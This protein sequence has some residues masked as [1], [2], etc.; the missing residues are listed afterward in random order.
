MHVKSLA[1]IATIALYIGTANFT[2]LASGSTDLVRIPGG[3]SGMTA[4]ATVEGTVPASA[5]V[6]VAITLPLRNQPEL[7]ALLDDLYNPLSPRY[8]HFLTPEQFTAEYSPTLSDYEVVANYARRSGLTIIGTHANR[9]ILDVTAP[10]SIVS[11][12]F[13]VHLRTWSS[14]TGEHFMAPD[15]APS[16]PAVVAAKVQSV[17]GLENAQKWHTHITQPDASVLNFQQPFQVGSGPN[18]ALSPNDIKSAYHL[19]TL[20]LTGTGQTLALFELDGF[21]QADVNAYRNY[22]GIG[23]P[24]DSVVLLDGFS[25][26]AGNGASEVTLDIQLMNALA[27]GAKVMVYEAPNSN[28]GVVDAYARIASDNIA[29]EVSSSWGLA[30]SQMTAGVESSENSSFQQMATQGQ[31]VFAA[32]GDSGAYDNGSTLSV[33]DPAS[34]QMMTG[35]G[36]TRLSVNTDHSWASE[37]TWNNGSISAGAGGGGVSVVWSKPSYQNGFG[38]SATARN[39][40]DVSLDADPNSGY[41]IYFGGTW[42]IYGGT[43]CAAPLWAAFTGLVNEQRIANQQSTIGFINP[44]IY[45]IGA[46]SRYAADFHD[47]NDGSTNLH[48]TAVNGFDDATGW[49]TFIG[50]ALLSDLAPSPVLA[51]PTSL[52][53]TGVSTSEIDLTWATVSGASSYNVYRSTTASGPYS[54]IASGLTTASYADKTLPAST[55]YYYAVASASGSN[56]SVLS[57]DVS[58]TT[59]ASTGP[60]TTVVVGPSADTF[61]NDGSSANTNFGTNA[62]LLIKNAGTANYDRVTYLK[63]DL[64]KVT[65]TISAAKLALTL[66]AVYAPSGVTSMPV[67]AFGVADTTWTESGM[68]WNTA[69]ASDNLTNSITSTGT[70][71]NST[72]VPT[73]LGTYSWDLSSYLA[74]KAGK[75]VTIQLM[76]D[77]Y[78]GTVLLFNSKEA[79][80]NPPALTLTVGGTATPPVAP[81]SLTATAISTSE[82][83]LSWPSSMGATSYTVGRATLSGG[84]YTTLGTPTGT[85]FNDTTASAS[86][87]YFYVVKAVSNAG[88]SGP[89]P[90]ASATTLTPAPLA[91]TSLTA[92]AVS[93]TQI[94]LSWSS[95]AGATSYSVNRSTTSGGPYTSIGTSTSTTFSDTAASPA[96]KYYYVVKSVSVNGT[97]GP[98][99]EA[100]ATTLTP[101]PLPPASLT[102]TAVSTTE[103]DLSWPS[104]IGATSYSVGRST[105]SGGPYTTVGTPTGTTYNDTSDSASTTYYYVVTAVNS[106]GSSGLSPQASATTLTPAPL[107]PASLTATDISTSEI[108]LSWTS[109]AGATSYSVGRSTTSGGPYTVVG[110]PT[111]TTFND[112]TAAASTK[113]YYIVKAVSSNGTSGPSPEASASTGTPAPNAPTSLT[114]TTISS[115]EIDLSWAGSTGATSYTVDRSTTSGGPYATVGTSTTLSLKDTSASPSTKYYYVVKAVNS[116]GSSGPSPE[117]SATTLAAPPAAPATLTATAVSTSTINLSWSASAGATSYGVYRS[118]TSGGP[119]SSVGT[120]TT[121]SYSDTTGLSATQYYYV[122]KAVGVGGTSAASPEATATTLAVST[123]SQSMAAIDDVFVNDGNSSGSNFGSASYLIVKNAGAPNYDRVAYLKF[124]LTHVTSVPKS[125]V[126][127]MTVSQVNSVYSSPVTVKVFGVADTSWTSASLTWNLAVSNDNLTNSVTSTGT[128]AGSTSLSPVIGPASWNLTS[129]LAGKIGSVVTLQVIDDTN[130][131]TGFV[132]NSVR[133]ATGKPTLTLTF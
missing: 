132:F 121:T 40:P 41:A 74:D 79:A 102:A 125:A 100:S 57:S 96:T 107:A 29:K 122:V 45:G 81:A 109:S 50:D 106:N 116:N 51:A 37:T 42:T 47:I 68:T 59:M 15:A 5:T 48:Y 108:D 4:G 33:D 75:I 88:T 26:A 66:N 60:T 128:F 99:P 13:A 31:S 2:A 70:Y 91:P 67:Q 133:A 129:Y 27:P 11:R 105:T 21:N 6:D 38:Y 93:A 25:G 115:T 83:D 85:T 110:T 14:D 8:H 77:K 18:N 49:G 54:E 16:L 95:S 119:Y 104:S 3:I 58:A 56:V 20:P 65:G 80:S 118:T 12:A 103:I 78:D 123:A 111:A 36:G 69:V 28:T 24:V 97:S 86:T 35:V 130:T 17:I 7:N 39:V 114:A 44:S 52:S 63:F 117:A 62:S 53:A 9:T 98:S 82:I 22:F 34:Q 19:N 87:K 30:E 23:G 10:A 64:T 89:S 90:E 131:G 112:T 120:S 43:S 76:D 71:I 127:S 84:P 124:D 126:L 46:G 73:T 55:T 61:V 1:F 113:Y 72:V 92:T 32:A 94:N 101:A